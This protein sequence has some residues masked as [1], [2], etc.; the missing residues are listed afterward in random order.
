MRPHGLK[1]GE[2]ALPEKEEPFSSYASLEHMVHF[3]NTIQHLE[4]RLQT[5]QE[6]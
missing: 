5:G 4:E 2:K 3:F 1:Q 6:A